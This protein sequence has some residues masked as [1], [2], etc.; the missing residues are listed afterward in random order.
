MEMLIILDALKRASPARITAV[1]PYYSSYG[2]SI[3]LIKAIVRSFESEECNLSKTWNFNSEVEDNQLWQRDEISIESRLFSAMV[4]CRKFRNNHVDKAINDLFKRC[5]NVISINKSMNTEA[6]GD[7][8]D[9]ILKFKVPLED[10]AK[11]LLVI[12][13][14]YYFK[15]Y[16]E[17]LVDYINAI[18]LIQI[19]PN[20]ADDEE[21]Y[22]LKEQFIE[23]YEY[24]V[25][26]LDH[27]WDYDS[28]IIPDDY[29]INI[30]YLNRIASFFDV[31]IS[32]GVGKLTAIGHRFDEE[33]I[34]AMEDSID[35]DYES[36]R[37]NMEIEQEQI[38]KMFSELKAK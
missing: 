32:E 24:Y 1:I 10:D 21:I 33:M 8:I 30:D 36:W 19:Y 14:P 9:Y 28:I 7:V 26:E 22:K 37:E 35:L 34:I 27:V 38:D 12:V 17:Y 13:K 31:D 6:F 20:I 18:N 25:R 23:Y 11:E 16:I 29:C 15:N 3:K 4:V 2:N 5:I